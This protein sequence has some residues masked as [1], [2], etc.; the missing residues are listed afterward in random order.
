MKKM[1]MLLCL[2]PALANTEARAQWAELDSATKLYRNKKSYALTKDYV[3]YQNNAVTE[4]LSSV[5]M[6]EGENVYEDYKSVEY[7]KSEGLSLVAEHTTKS[8]FVYRKPA[9]GKSESGGLHGLD[10]LLLKKLVDSALVNVTETGERS[11]EI[12]Y[13]KSYTVQKATLWLNPDYSLKKIRIE[14]NPAYLEKGIRSQALVCEMTET[15]TEAKAEKLDLTHYITKKGGSYVLSP[16]YKT[17]RL[18][19]LTQTK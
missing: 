16:A 6:Q 8:L 17:Y 14:Y 3:L 18:L 1:L 9:A 15:K 11:I 19:D 2:L 10:S 7:L 12:R 13:H 5:Y 4:K